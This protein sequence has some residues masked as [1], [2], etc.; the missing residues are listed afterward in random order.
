VI[1]S[2]VVAVKICNHK[3]L[4]SLVSLDQVDVAFSPGKGLNVEHV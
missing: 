3:S 1:E 4:P 2:Y